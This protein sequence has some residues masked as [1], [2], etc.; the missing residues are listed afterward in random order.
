MRETVQLPES[1]WYMI[2][3]FRESVLCCIVCNLGT[4]LDNLV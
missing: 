3:S 1:N 2:L 4:S